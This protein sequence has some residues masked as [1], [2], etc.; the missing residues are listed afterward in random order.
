MILSL[1]ITNFGLIE[2]LKLPLKPGLTV[3]TGETGAGKS[4]II[5][6]LQVALGGRAYGEYI[7]SGK[8]KALVQAVFEIG[9]L[10]DL[11][12]VL[13]S[14][15]LEPEDDYL[16]LT[17]QLSRSGRNFCRVNGQVTTLQLY[18]QVGNFLLD[19]HGQ[20]EQ[21]SLLNTGRHMELL[22]RF[23]GEKLLDTKAK[24][25]KIFREWQSAKQ[26]L[27]EIRANRRERVRKADMLRF[28]V[29]EIDSALL[30]ENEEEDLIAEK[31][32]VANAETI[33]QLAHSGYVALY[34]GDSYAPSAV[35]QLGKAVVSLE[36]LKEFDAGIEPL[37]EAVSSA[38]YQVE[39]AARDLASYR[40]NVEFQP[41]RLDQIE[42]RL[43]E[44]SRL[45]LK[46][47]ESVAKILSYRD[48][49]VAEL[50][51]LDNSEEMESAL[52]QE[53][54]KL[55]Q[56]YEKYA[57]QLTELR[58]NAANK[59]KSAVEKELHDLEMK[60]VLLE[61]RLTPSEQG[62]HGVE[63]VE[64]VISTNPGEPPKPLA[65]VASGGEL[66]RI[67]L[68]FKNIFASV[69]QIPSLVFD[70]VDT[71]IGGKTLQA[72]ARKLE[73]L[74]HYRQTMVVTHAPTIAALADNHFHVHK[75]S[76][77]DQTSIEI[78]LLKGQDRVKELARMLGGK[79]MSQTV[80]QHARQLLE[81]K[82][83]QKL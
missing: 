23:S 60:G 38:L 78:T 34:A 27:D 40:D 67:M 26:R 15:G 58:V 51:E 24:A 18:K 43:S 76:N 45:K 16:I 1:E 5:D 42:N 41:G 39:E 30:K 37:L 66:S 6:A 81:Q 56:S 4:I 12:E 64:F 19:L 54:L 36:K 3:L 7:Q 71:G 74:S 59:L 73:D 70:E 14:T 52:D 32:C 25:K 20:H 62:P 31:T 35:D 22:D 53:C 79:E 29:E 33:A 55:G 44:I 50:E 46:Y 72:V 21:Q 77:A 57:H 10:P 63:E 28:Q 48:Y 11:R 83:P 17:R 82:M 2:G 13:E 69:D 61:A 75:H 49:A 9:N 47:G 68:A 65:K 80:L 8:E